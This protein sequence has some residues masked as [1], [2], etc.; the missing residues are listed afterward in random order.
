MPLQEICQKYIDG[1]MTRIEVFRS[2]CGERKF[3]Q[4]DVGDY[5]SVE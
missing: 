2:I 1:F 4:K 5:L 3:L